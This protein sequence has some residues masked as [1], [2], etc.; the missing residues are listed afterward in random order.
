MPELRSLKACSTHA[1]LRNLLQTLTLCSL[2]ARQCMLPTVVRHGPLQVDVPSRSASA[3]ELA[4]LQLPGDVPSE[5]K[6]AMVA[7][8]TA[9]P[10]GVA[11]GW[12][13]LV[14]KSSQRCGE[15]GAPELGIRQNF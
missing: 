15:G 9:L 11:A 13:L 14:A 3:R 1:S 4:Q 8:M 6:A 5:G 2:A 12:M 10:F 7:L